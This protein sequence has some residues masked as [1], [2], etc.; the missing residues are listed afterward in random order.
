LETKS[1]ISEGKCANLHS[2]A[3]DNRN[4]LFDFYPIL[5]ESRCRNWKSEYLVAREGR[6]QARSCDGHRSITEPRH[7]QIVDDGVAIGTRPIDQA[8]FSKL[9]MN[10]ISLK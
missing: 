4:V 7:I 1:I 5:G 3:S 2:C 6:N 10:A 9:G 8:S